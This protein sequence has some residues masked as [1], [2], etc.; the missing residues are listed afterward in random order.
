[1]IKYPDIENSFRMATIENLGRYDGLFVAEEKIDGSNFQIEIDR[2]GNKTFYSRNHPLSENSKFYGFQDVV[3]RQEFV[4]LFEKVSEYCS[5]QNYTSI[6]LFGEL[7]GKGINGRV[8]YGSSK[9]IVFFDAFVEKENTITW[10]TRVQLEV[11]FHVCEATDL[12]IPVLKSGTL[13]EL[14]SIDVENLQSAYSPTNDN[15]EGIV[16]KPYSVIVPT[17]FYK[18]VGT[19]DGTSPAYIKK[20]AQRFLETKGTRVKKPREKSEFEDV[21]LEYINDNRVKSVFSK[22]GV[23]PDKRYISKY[24]GFVIDDAYK[25]FKWDYPDYPDEDKKNIIKPAGNAVAKILLGYC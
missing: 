16:I 18:E 8:N 20:K 24:I 19:M 10:L 17:D 15:A 4:E 1:M 11:L 14:L 3:E 22:E 7:Y 21:F 13:E 2:N 5:S 12:L 9:N 6:H 23:I 25:D